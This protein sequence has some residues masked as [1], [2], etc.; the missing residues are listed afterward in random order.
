MLDAANFWDRAAEKYAKSP[1][2][3]MK[4][5][6]DT[7]DRT[8]SYLAAEDRVLEVGCGT[9]STALLLAPGV[10]Q[11]IAS[12]ISGNMVAIGAGKA[13]DQG[14]A[15]IKFVQAGL[16]GDAIS[17]GPYDAV[18][19][20]NVVHLVEDTPAAIRRIHAL[21]KPGGLFISKTVTTIGKSASLKFRLIKLLLPLLQMIGKAPF[22]RFM[23]QA[24]LDQAITA[25]GFEIIEAGYIPPTAL[26]R[27]I[28]AR[29]VGKPD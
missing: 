28:V 14:V 18:L 22:V 5:Y 11:I 17:P 27:Y 26:S 16:D 9:G 4:G 23:T 7:L 24:E 13:R 10:K 25:G 29:K 3:D 8:R 20:L 12:D 2:A 21:L 15:N 6:T 19:A 1:I